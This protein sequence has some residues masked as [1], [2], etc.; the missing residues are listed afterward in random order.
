MDTQGSEVDIMR[1]GTK[2]IDKAVMVILEMSYVD[3]NIGAPKAREV[4]EYMKEIGY[5]RGLKVG[6]SNHYFKDLNMKDYRPIQEDFV[7]IN[8][9]YIT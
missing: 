6:Q 9:K 7:Y 8:T 2:L 3:Y 4:D 1:G 5:Q